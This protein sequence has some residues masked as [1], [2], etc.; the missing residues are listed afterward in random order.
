MN[1]KLPASLQRLWGLGERA[2]REPRLGLSLERIVRAAVELADAGGLD[3]VSMSRVA[4]RLGFTTSSCSSCTTRR[5][6]RHPRTKPTPTTGAPVWNGG[7]R[8]NT[9]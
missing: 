1:D 3:A 8:S 4:E 2:E 7:A 5:G 9:P 6:S